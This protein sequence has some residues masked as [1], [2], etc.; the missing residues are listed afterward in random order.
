MEPA[1]FTDVQDGMFIAIEE[2]FGPVMI[3]SKF[4]DGYVILFH[5]VLSIFCIIAKSNSN[6]RR[7]FMDIKIN[8][9]EI[10]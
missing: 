8:H 9:I 5:A 10:F 1:V 6:H 4:K 7:C 2:S 3:I